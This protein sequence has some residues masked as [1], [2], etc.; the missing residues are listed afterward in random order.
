MSLLEDIH[1]NRKR[2][3]AEI[4]RRAALVPQKEVQPTYFIK[5]TPFGVKKINPM[6]PVKARKPIVESDWWHRMWFYDLVNF[7]PRA[8]SRLTIAMVLDAV[9]NHY[10]LSKTEIISA[11]RTFDIVRPRQVAYYLAKKLTGRTLQEIGRR[12]GG[13]DHTSC[14]SGIRKIEKLRQSD[15]KLEAD[16]HAIAAALGGSLG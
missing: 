9:S 4:A 6:K 12:L 14:L 7:T 13:R 16:L 5:N 10:A 8:P 1:Q 11:R 2:F 15:E 3:H